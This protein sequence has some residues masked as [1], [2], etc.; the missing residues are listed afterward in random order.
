MKHL[1]GIIATY[2]HWDEGE[3]LYIL[4]FRL[5]VHDLDSLF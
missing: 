4:S 3:N 2:G 1:L 5:P